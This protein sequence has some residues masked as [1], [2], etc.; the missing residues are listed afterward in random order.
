MLVEFDH[1]G[2]RYTTEQE[3]LRDINLKL[4]KGSFFYLTGASGAGKTSL[5]RLIYL[6]QK[7]SHGRIK[8]FGKDIET[9]KR[10]DL[11]FLRRHIG[12]VFQDFRLIN[13]LSVFDNVA[14]PLCIRGENRKKISNNVSELLEWVGLYRQRNQKPLSLSGGQQQRAAIARAVITRPR[15]LLADEPTGN[16]DEDTAKKL[17]YLFEQMNLNGTTV[18]IATHNRELLRL[19][20]HPVVHLEE[21][22][23]HFQNVN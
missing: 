13:H 5:L 22:T 16:V 18:V 3:V 15:L 8:I 19:F 11:P 20:P 14:L 2:M 4:A 9:V 21:A 6:A 17:L 1:V 23:L 7:P 10:N 12:V